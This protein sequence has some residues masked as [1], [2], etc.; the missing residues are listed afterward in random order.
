[1]IGKLDTQ[2]I[3]RTSA[4]GTHCIGCGVCAALCPAHALGMRWDQFGQYQVSGPSECAAGCGLCVQVCPFAF[5]GPGAA[6]DLGGEPSGARDTDA[7]GPHLSCYV[8]HV[9]EGRWRASSASGGL[10]RWLLAAALHQGLVSRVACVVPTG[11]PDCLFRFQVLDSGEEL[12]GAGGSAYYPVELSTV[13]TRVLREERRSAVV[14]LPCFV[15][16]IRLAQAQSAVLRERLPLVVGLACGQLKARSFTEFLLRSCGMPP[17]HVTQVAFRSKE[18]AHRGTDFRFVARSGGRTSSLPFA[19]SA[20]AQAWTTGQFKPRACT[21]CDD[22]FAELADASAMDA[23]LPGYTADPRGTS[24]VV[25]R[26]AIAAELLDGGVRSGQLAV[27]A[28][29]AELVARSQRALIYAKREALSHRLWLATARGEPVPPT[30]VRPRRPTPYHAALRSAE[31]AVRSG[32]HQAM[33]EQCAERNEGLE[34]YHRRMRAPL[35]RLAALRAPLLSMAKAGAG[36][37]RMGRLVGG[38]RGHS[39]DG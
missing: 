38:R 36:L 26:S 33:L 2:E 25:A 24:L 7:L 28:I 12:R 23:W 20:Y 21:F 3:A 4:C 16:A 19:H 27:E 37:R 30:R 1:M 31:E 22:V 32:S 17:A 8:G 6:A 11:E 35:A 9:A 34:L 14:A 18:G 13:L 15:R 5:R 39:V 29:P 10:A